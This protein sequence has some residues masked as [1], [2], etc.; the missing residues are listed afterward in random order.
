MTFKNVLFKASEKTQRRGKRHPE[1][2]NEEVRI[3]RLWIPQ[4]MR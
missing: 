2:R 1:S 4:K 3:K